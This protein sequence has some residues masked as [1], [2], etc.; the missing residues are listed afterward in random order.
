MNKSKIAVL[1]RRTVLS[2]NVSFSTAC[3]PTP[4]I[5]ETLVYVSSHPGRRWTRGNAQLD[6]TASAFDPYYGA[7]VTDTDATV[8]RLKPIR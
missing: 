4:T 8:V 6:T 3:G 2:G 5:V 1:N 7:D